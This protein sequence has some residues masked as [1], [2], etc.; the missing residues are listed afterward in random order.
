MTI[1]KRSDN[2]IFDDIAFSV[3]LA[4][5]VLM[6]FIIIFLITV[7]FDLSLDI[8]IFYSVIIGA[9]ISLSS[10][11]IINNL[12]SGLIII[13]FI[14]PYRIYDYVAISGLEGVVTE[15]TLNYTKIKSIDGNFILIPNRTILR[16]DIINYTIYKEREALT[17]KVSNLKRYFDDI[18]AP[19]LTQYTFQMSAPIE[20]MAL[21]TYAFNIVFDE[22]ESKFAYRPK[23]FIYSLGLKVDY[24]II[25]FAIS[26]RTIRKNLKLF[27]M[28]LIEELYSDHLKTEILQKD[29]SAIQDVA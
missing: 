19:V 18:K 20:T 23:N 12:L 28:R 7:F 15:I 2:L 4:S 10:I 29:D 13:L 16:T 25:I 6:G 22:F 1:V 8:F 24:Q 26:S 9:V 5:K 11:Q 17:A 21:H 14:R 27:K 3:S